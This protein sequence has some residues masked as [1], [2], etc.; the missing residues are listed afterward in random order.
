MITWIL[1]LLVVVTITTRLH[2]SFVAPR[3]KGT[4]WWQ[5]SHHLRGLVGYPCFIMECMV[6]DFKR[7]GIMSIA[8]WLIVFF[9]GFYFLPSN[10]PR[11]PNAGEMETTAFILGAGSV[12][13]FFAGY[14]AFAMLQSIEDPYSLADQF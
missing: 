7:S 11:F 9:S 12:G 1:L 5:V 6:D 13:W 3:P 10:V 8:G 2:A 4:L 14:F